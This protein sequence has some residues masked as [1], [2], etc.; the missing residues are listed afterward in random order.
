M[1][2]SNTYKAIATTTATGSALVSFTSITSSYTDLVF[3]C[4]LKAANSVDINVTVNGDTGTNYSRT[5]LTGDGGTASSSRQTSKA[6]FQPDSNGYVTN[7]MSQIT[8]IHFMNYSNATTYK[9]FLSRTGN[10]EVGVDATVGL[11]RSTSAINRI[12]I[13]PIGA[14]YFSSGSTFTLYGILAA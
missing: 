12:D 6:Y 14:T 5:V 13:A 3:V 9:T 7:T 4:N 11:W 2:V 10:W 8:T 1:A